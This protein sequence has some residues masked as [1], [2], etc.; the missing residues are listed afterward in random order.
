MSRQI[1]NVQYQV[2]YVPCRLCGGQGRD[3]Y[4]HGM[5]CRKCDGQKRVPTPAARKAE[6]AIARYGRDLLA[7]KAEG[8]QVTQDD[9]RNLAEFIDGLRGAS[10][11][12]E[13][14]D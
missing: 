12:V 1:V 4:S 11:L 8:E 6:E 5:S 10:A 9:F 2:R 13:Y 14:A 7:G 3:P